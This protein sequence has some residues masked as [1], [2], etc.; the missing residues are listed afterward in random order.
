VDL[1]Y[2]LI[3]AA[4]LIKGEGFR[5]E[6]AALAAVRA[7]RDIVPGWRSAAALVGPVEVGSYTRHPRLGNT[8]RVVWRDSA[9][10]WMQ[11]RVGLRNPGA[12]AAAAF[13]ASHAADLPTVWGLNL[14]VS[15]GLADDGR[16]RD[17]L[18]EAAGFF[19]K[20]FSGLEAGPA[21]LTL[22]LSCP[23]TEDDPHGTQS[24][25]L[26]RE[27]CT[28]LVHAVE[29]PVWVKLGPDLS[30]AQLV[31]LVDVFGA[32]GVRA[33][34]ATNTLAQPVPSGHGTA[35]VSGSRLRDQ[36]LDTVTR[37]KRAVDVSAAP[38]DIVGGGG[39]LKGDDL[40]A[41]TDA[42]AVAAMLYTALVLRGPLA[43]A[44][45]LREAEREA[46]EARPDA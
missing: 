36:A 14:A 25:E 8:G 41:F 11:N 22:N 15:P 33:V 35:G 43:G 42:G 20:A 5:D 45:I 46:Q 16:A 26:A 2:P 28:A 30:D 38:L 18:V 19:T 37:L 10:G 24:A 4:G 1:P 34:V 12:R 39:I 6:E 21:W 31:A 23:N 17:E 3:L 29:M 9:A 40:R 44:L 27:L 32:T 13:L 7:G